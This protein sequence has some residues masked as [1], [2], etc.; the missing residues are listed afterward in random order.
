[1]YPISLLVFMLEINFE[2]IFS[3]LEEIQEK[4]DKVLMRG[5]NGKE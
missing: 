1:M 4:L 3:Q 5:N 2:K